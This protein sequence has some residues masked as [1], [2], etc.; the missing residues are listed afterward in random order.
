MF[1]ISKLEGSDITIAGIEL[2]FYPESRHQVCYAFD[3]NTVVQSKSAT[4]ECM[5]CRCHASA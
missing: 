3:S 5:A 4:D 1:C 2:A